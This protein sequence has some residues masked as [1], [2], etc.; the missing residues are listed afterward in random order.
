MNINALGN[1]L[2][3][4]HVAPVMKKNGQGSIVNISSLAGINGS[5]SISAYTASK[6]ATRT[7]TKGAAVNLGPHHIRVNSIH[8]GYIETPMIIKKFLGK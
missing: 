7:L 4:K 2:G 1:I 8:P 3:I 6:G 5:A